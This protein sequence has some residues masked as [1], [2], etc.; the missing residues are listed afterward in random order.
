MKKW[1]D[2]SGN[3]GDIVISSRIRLAR[4][5]SKYPFLDRMDDGQKQEL[6][7]EVENKLK[8]LN[9]GDNQLELIW[10]DQITPN[11]KSALVE[12][13]LVSPDFVK[14]YGE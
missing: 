8:E 13:H 9:L 14:H 3:D 1:Y 2:A 6:N 10:P 7:H 11:Q 12:Q 5:L 4:N